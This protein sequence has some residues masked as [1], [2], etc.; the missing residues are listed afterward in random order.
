MRCVF[1]R[2]RIALAFILFSR[3]FSS[4]AISAAHIV[5]R[6]TNIELA[7]HGQCPEQS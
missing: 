4:E 2:G 5:F 7:E 6:T 1:S 3:I